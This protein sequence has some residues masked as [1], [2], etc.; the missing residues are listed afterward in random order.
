MNATSTL[1]IILQNKGNHFS[2]QM[3]MIIS[4]VDRDIDLHLPSRA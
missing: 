4:E 3:K 2:F 1:S